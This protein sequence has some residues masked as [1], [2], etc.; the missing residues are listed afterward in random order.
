MLFRSYS[1]NETIFGELL[2]ASTKHGICYLG[3]TNDLQNNFSAL[4]DRFPK[5]N[6]VQQKNEMHQNVL[7]IF[8]PDWADVKKIKLHLLG[9]DFQM[10]VWKKL[11][12]IPTG[13]LTTYGTLATQIHKPKAARA[14][15]TAIGNNPIAFLIPCHRVIQT[16]GALGGYRWGNTRK[17]A[18]IGW[19]ASQK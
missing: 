8:T 1:L 6:F 15:G 16:S 17:L 9:T 18:M 19:E 13:D 12:Q 3:F 10:Q 14:V 2:I 5:A 4:E 11:L 7:L